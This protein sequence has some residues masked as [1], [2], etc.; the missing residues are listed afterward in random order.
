M[1]G[2]G[3]P[4]SATRRDRRASTERRRLRDGLRIELE[5]VDQIT[6]RVVVEHELGNPRSGDA[7]ELRRGRDGHEVG[8]SSSSNADIEPKSTSLA[9]TPS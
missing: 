2:A 1:S 9:Q 5:L 4:R 3:E 8:R 6:G 7:D